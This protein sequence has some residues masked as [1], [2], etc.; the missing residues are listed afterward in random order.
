MNIRWIR[1]GLLAVAAICCL[2]RVSPGYS[3]LTHEAIIDSCWKTDIQPL[4]IKR[5]P[6]A[7]AD[8][9]KE[10]YAH[11]YGGAIIQD[12]GYY[13]FASKFFSDLAHY[14]RSG[15]FVEALIQDSQDIDE[16]AFALGALCHYAADNDGHPIAV[17]KS[18]PLLYPKL[19]RKYGNSVTYEEDT[20]AHLR[21]EFGFDVVQV[22]H[23]QYASNSYHNF[24]GFKVSKPLLE[25]AFQDTYGIELKSIFTD[26]DL[27]LGTYRYSVSTIIPEMTRVAWETHKSDIEKL[28]PGMTRAKFRYRIARG[29]YEK[30]FGTHYKQP[31]LGTKVL[32][33]IIRIV[34]KIGPF[35]GLAIKPSNQQTEKL[36]ADSFTA[37]V[38]FYRQL[39]KNVQ[40]GDLNLPNRDFDTGRPTSPGEY[41]LADQTYEKLL[42]ALAKH[43]FENVTPDLRQNILAFF[44]NP[45]QH[46]AATKAERGEWQKTLTEL[47]ELKNPGTGT[48][49]APKQGAKQ[50]PPEH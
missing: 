18:V 22:A 19:R 1:H 48:S 23:G 17:N 24:I 5:F 16:Y 45:Q 47:D 41:H 15:D 10:A 11:A 12:M 38:D 32:A 29:S 43:K 33:F 31:G 4:L 42:A 36:F 30:E 28:S 26:L 35:K 7:T 20:A 21:T 8:Q 50:P 2:A 46:N 40:A 25:R 49:P 13:P 9:L 27:A 39:L 3:V 14:V 34:P 37:T 6:N 44:A